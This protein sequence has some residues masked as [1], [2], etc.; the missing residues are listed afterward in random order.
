MLLHTICKILSLLS[1]L[2]VILILYVIRYRRSH[3]PPIRQSG[4]TTSV[5]SV[6]SSP[7]SSSSSSCGHRTPPSWSSIVTLRG[8]G[9]RTS[10]PSSWRTWIAASTVSSTGRPTRTFAKPTPDFWSPSS[11][12]G[13]GDLSPRRRINKRRS[14]QT[15]TVAPWARHQIYKP[16][17]NAT[18][19]FCDVN[20]IYEQHHMPGDQKELSFYARLD[21]E[22]I[23][24]IIF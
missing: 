21:S 6:A 7:S 11:P 19:L 12:A 8:Q 2:C 23:F 5:S 15:P 3:R 22:Y 9:H 13:C 16:L 4:T 17:I 24:L 20:K 18:H 10:S 14:Y 1:S